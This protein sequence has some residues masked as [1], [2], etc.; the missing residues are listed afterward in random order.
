MTQ[1]VK[2][3]IKTLF[4]AAL[5]GHMEVVKFLILKV[6]CDPKS[7]NSANATPLHAAI[8]G[9]LNV[10][11]FFIFDQN[12][13]KN[14]PGGLYGRTPLHYDDCDPS[15][16][17]K[18]KSTSLHLAT[19]KDILKFFISNKSCNPNLPAWHGRT[20]PHFC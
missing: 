8:N 4:M 11:Q 12:C 15:C 18:D 5:G 3:L 17:N 2:T 10:T 13:D 19:K 7:R 6:N 16:T 9:H 14:T 20:P 1:C